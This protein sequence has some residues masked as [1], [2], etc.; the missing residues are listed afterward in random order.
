EGG[1]VKYNPLYIHASVGLGKTH[2]LQAIGHEVRTTLPHVKALYLTA[3]HFMYRFVQALQSQ[4][5]I[6]FKD[7][8]RGIDLLLT[9]DLQ[10]L[11]GKQMQ[12]EFCHTLNTLID[13]AKQVVVAADRA[14]IELETLD[15]RVR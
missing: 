1:L 12:Q 10:F 15:E 2:L 6:A 9:D 7:M 4:S 8:L 11:H 14:P 3:E 13:G 5:A